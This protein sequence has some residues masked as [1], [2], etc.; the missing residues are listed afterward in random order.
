M[1]EETK[2]PWTYF[3]DAFWECNNSQ[4]QRQTVL[5]PSN[6]DRPFI[7]SSVEGKDSL[8]LKYL[9]PVSSCTALTICKSKCT[10]NFV[11]NASYSSCCGPQSLY[12]C[13]PGKN[14]VAK[15]DLQKFSLTCCNSYNNLR[16]L[17]LKYGQNPKLSCKISIMTSDM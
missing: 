17:A 16:H 14:L 2:Q 8:N 12:Y 15:V 10:L 4:L 5:G 6:K 9:W 3:Q 13:K 1:E 7:Y 11:L